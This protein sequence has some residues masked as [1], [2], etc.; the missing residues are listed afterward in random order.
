M[1]YCA[2]IIKDPTLARA[3]EIARSLQANLDGR[4]VEEQARL[5]PQL[6]ALLDRRAGPER[7]VGTL[8]AVA[9]LACPDGLPN[10]R[11]CG[12]PETPCTG[13]DHC[14]Y[15]GT[16]H[17]VAPYRLVVARGYALVELDA[18]PGASQVWDRGSLTFVPRTVD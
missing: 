15:C 13:P 9:A 6:E 10:C 3:Q 1:D 17:G 14:P 5:R 8:H 11:N 4:S 12:D 18:L 7:P 16:R 2:V